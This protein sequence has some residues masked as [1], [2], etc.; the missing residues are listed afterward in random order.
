MNGGHRWRAHCGPR[1]CVYG[2]AARAFS[3]CACGMNCGSVLL[4]TPR[5]FTFFQFVFP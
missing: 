3:F 1:G 5:L 2:H 4:S